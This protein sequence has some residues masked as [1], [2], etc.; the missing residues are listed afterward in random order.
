VIV[1][2]EPGR[3]PRPGTAVGLAVE[4]DAVQY[5]EPITGRRLYAGR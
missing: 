4:T 5:F 3:A 1:R 2:C